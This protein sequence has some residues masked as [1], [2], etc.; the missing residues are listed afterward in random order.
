MGLEKD[1][2]DHGIKDPPALLQELKARYVTGQKLKF[3]AQHEYNQVV[4]QSDW[5][6]LCVQVGNMSYEP[7]T[8]PTWDNPGADVGL[9]QMDLDLA[10]AYPELLVPDPYGVAQQWLIQDTRN[11]LIEQILELP[12]FKQAWAM[13]Q[14]EEEEEEAEE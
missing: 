10:S 5:A 6:N 14:P 8:A 7:G 11:W 3:E 2:L 13:V 4:V 9:G 1:M 12:G